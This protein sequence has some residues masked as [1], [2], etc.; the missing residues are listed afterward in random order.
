MQLNQ[1][2]DIISQNL[3]AFSEKAKKNGKRKERKI[4][5]EPALTA[6][7]HGF[8]I[9]KHNWDGTEAKAEVGW[10]TIVPPAA[11]VQGRAEAGAERAPRTHVDTSW[12]QKGTPLFVLMY[13]FELSVTAS[14]VSY[15][16]TE[17]AAVAKDSYKNIFSP[18]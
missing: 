3:T 9:R 18:S 17:H 15:I 10:E 6:K 16:C 2:H 5:K 4:R 14:A 8:V 11:E 1:L 12:I 13:S 7:N